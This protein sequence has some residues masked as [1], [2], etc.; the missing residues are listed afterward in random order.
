MNLFDP[1][2]L[3]GVTLRNRIGVAPMCQYSA[4]DGV[5]NHWHLVHLGS[6]A[7][8]GAGLVISEATSVTA[9]GRISPADT[10]LYSD[11]QIDAWVPITRFITE[12]GAVPGVQ[13]AH[14]GRKASTDVP[15]RG[16]APV[17]AEQGGW[18]PLRAPSAVAFRPGH[19]VPAALGLDGIAGVVAAF[20]SAAERALAA[21]F[22]LAEVHAAHGYLLHQFLSPLSNQRDDAYG[23]AFDNR[24]RI[25]REVVAAV[26]EVWPER[27]PLL[28]R[29]SAT[30]WADAGGWTVDDSVALARQLRP[31]GVDLIDVSSGG[32]LPNAAI[33][34][35]PGFQ[36]PFAAR[37]R[38]EADIATAAVG[39]ITE[40]QQAQSIIESGEADLVL[41]ARELLRDP[42]WP[43]H[44]SVAL[45]CPLPAPEQYARAW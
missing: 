19:P 8:G 31:L 24:T 39:L 12:A 42:Y 18:S 27:L 34:V 16:G 40:A 29:I 32:S 5:P 21:G 44:A 38:H 4:V 15:W 45:G 23:G 6:R 10:G 7:V 41:L 33:P 26:R 1:L 36:V 14:A 2:K 25:V 20:R 9:E 13:L 22:Q 35:A 43:Y 3:R 17:D 28:V 11:A 30:D 37:I